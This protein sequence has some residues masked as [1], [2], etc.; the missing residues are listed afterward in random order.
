MFAPGAS[1]IPVVRIQLSRVAFG[2]HN[3]STSSGNGMIDSGIDY[4]YPILA[5]V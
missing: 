4:R 2:F 5:L 1:N 3:N